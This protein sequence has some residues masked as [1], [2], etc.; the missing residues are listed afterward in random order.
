M[1]R[2]EPGQRKDPN[3]QAF[4][5]QVVTP[6]YYSHKRRPRVEVIAS[7]RGWDP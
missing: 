4:Y 5:S 6:F 7:A 1:S 2:Q 3:R